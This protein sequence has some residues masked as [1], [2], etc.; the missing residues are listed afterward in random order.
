M[1]WALSSSRKC[2]CPSSSFAKE[3]GGMMHCAIEQWNWT[4]RNKKEAL[5]GRVPSSTHTCFHTL[6]PL[7]LQTN[8]AGS[9]QHISVQQAQINSFGRR[10][11]DLCITANL[12][13]RE[14][15]GCAAEH[16]R[17]KHRTSLNPQRNGCRMML[18]DHE[19]VSCSKVS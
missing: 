16:S 6:L 1:P 13:T 14:N 2:N 9:A 15:E 11:Q 17:T 5:G 12:K 8:C 10:Q 7:L 4:F 18:N 3:A 19:D